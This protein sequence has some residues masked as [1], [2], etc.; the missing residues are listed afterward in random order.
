MS[1]KTLAIVFL[2]GTLAVA[3]IASL[4]FPTMSGLP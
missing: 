4:M 3:V 2:L 1:D